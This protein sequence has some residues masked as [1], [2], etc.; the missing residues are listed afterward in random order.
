MAEP[1]TLDAND[2]NVAIVVNQR[3]FCIA[4]GAFVRIVAVAAEA[5]INAGNEAC[6]LIKNDANALAESLAGGWNDSFAPLVVRVFR[7]VMANHSAFVNGNIEAFTYIDSREMPARVILGIDVCGVREY[8]ESAMLDRFWGTFYLVFTVAARIVTSIFAE[9]NTPDVHDVLRLMHSRVVG[10]D[11]VAQMRTENPYIEP[12]HESKRDETLSLVSVKERRYDA[13]MR[14]REIIQA[15]GVLNPQLDI[16]EETTIRMFD[17]ISTQ[18]I[19]TV[20]KALSEMLDLDGEGNDDIKSICGALA[21]TV[22]GAMR[23]NPDVEISSLIQESKSVLASYNTK[24][25]QR[26]IYKTANRMQQLLR[27]KNKMASAMSG[28]VGGDATADLSRHIAD[29]IGMVGN[30]ANG[31]ARADQITRMRNKLDARRNAA[32]TATAE[33]TDTSG[34]E[35]VIAAVAEETATTRAGRNSRRHRKRK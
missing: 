35:H 27:D 15:L 10:L 31:T 21:G 3:T 19:E 18:S 1:T 32:M 16:T 17:E 2:E 23:D 13:P 11:L 8:I 4:L 14:L 9:R 7:K 12:I 30:A 24:K 33:A 25:S 5:G 29:V 20:N 34:M 22:M 26:G 28:A 6:V